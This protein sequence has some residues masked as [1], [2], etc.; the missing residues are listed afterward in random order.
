VPDESTR[1]GSPDLTSPYVGA[2]WALHDAGLSWD[3]IA[4]RFGTSRRFVHALALGFNL[5]DRWQQRIAALTCERM[6]VL[7]DA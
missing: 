3:E 2:L 7:A 4:Y 5:T 6:E 1:A